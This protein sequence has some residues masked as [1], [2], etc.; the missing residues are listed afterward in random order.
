MTRVVFSHQDIVL[1]LPSLTHIKNLWTTLSLIT[2][3]LDAYS[4]GNAKD[5]KQ[6]HNDKTS[7]WQ[8]SLVNIVMTIV[9]QDDNL[10][11]ICLSGSIIAEDKSADEQS[12]AIIGHFDGVGRLLKIWRE[13]TQ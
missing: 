12:R 2:K 3:T 10:K 9:D 8:K 5:W 11:T 1:E 4:L 6:M 13:T 7:R